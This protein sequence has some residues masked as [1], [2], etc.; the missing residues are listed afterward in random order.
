[1]LQHKKSKSQLDVGDRAKVIRPSNSRFK[2]LM[3]YRRYFLLRRDTACPPSLVDKMHKMN[4]RPEGAFQGQEV[5]MGILP[6]GIFAF[7]TTCRRA[8][9][10]AGVTHGQE[11]PLLAFRLA[12]PAKRSFA[13]ATS[14]RSGR[15]RLAIRT[16]GDGV[17]WLLANYATHAAM[18]Q[19]YHD[20]ITMKQHEN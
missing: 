5:F 19:A 14:T 20:I 9:D 4:R 18:A 3:D 17:N 12:G 15:K 6:L 8:C 1:M 10:A 11:L 13:S 16:Y 7:L 2:S